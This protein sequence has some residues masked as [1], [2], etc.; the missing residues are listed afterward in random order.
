M[1]NKGWGG[2]RPGAGR[3]PTGRKRVNLFVTPEEEAILKKQLA[4]IRNKEEIK[5]TNVINK[6]GHELDFN[7]A[8]DY[9]DDEIREALH[10]DMAPCGEQ[11]FLSAYEKAHEAKFNEDW[12]LSSSNPS[13]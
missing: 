6:N 11:E 12:F 3:K 2:K 1:A 5:M 8:V 9:M 4:T 7:A 10:S 13:W